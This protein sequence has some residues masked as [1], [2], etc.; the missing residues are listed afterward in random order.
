MYSKL[1]MQQHEPQKTM[2]QL[3]GRGASEEKAIS[4][5]L[6]VVLMLNVMKNSNYILH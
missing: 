2:V 5:P 6:V 1:K 3:G 4:A